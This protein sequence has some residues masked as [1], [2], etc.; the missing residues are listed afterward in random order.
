MNQV[1]TENFPKT[2]N[3]LKTRS[4]SIIYHQE[5]I[6]EKTTTKNVNV[7]YVDFGSEEKS[8]NK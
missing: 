7:I 6:C 2:K 1:S 8:R 3:H 4:L 5:K